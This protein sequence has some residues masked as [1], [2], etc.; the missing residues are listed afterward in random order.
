MI[1]IIMPYWNRMEHLKKS[2]ESLWELYY[3]LDFE[4]I[5]IDDGTSTVLQTLQ[6]E[7]FPT[8]MKVVELPKTTVAL[9]PCVPINRGVEVAQGD[10]IVLT[11]P[12]IIHREPILFDMKKALKSLGAKGYVI[13]A[14]WGVN[15]NKWLSHSSIKVGQNGRGKM[16][17]ESDLHFCTMMYKSFFLELEGFHEE[18]RDGQG[19]EDNDFLWK[20]HSSGAK[21]L[22]RDDLIVDHYSTPIQW[23]LGGLIKN[24]MLFEKRW[25]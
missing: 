3:K 16:P 10:I 19:Y 15:H 9:N 25:N 18:Y 6:A 22:I 13:A 11:N 5:I 7:H 2:L 20:L 12:E 14:T 21:F 23:P 1:S 8:Y 17:P 24:R 4:L